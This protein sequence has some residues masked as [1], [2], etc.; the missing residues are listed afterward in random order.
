MPMLPAPPPTSQS[1]SPGAGARTARL[2]ARTSRLVSWPSCSYA[3]SSSPGVSPRRLPVPS[4]THSTAS[5]LRS[6]PGGWSHRSAVPATRRSAGAP[7]CSS[8]TSRLGP[9]P[10]A[11][12]ASATTAG[13]VRSAQS[14]SSRRPWWTSSLAEESGRPTTL[15]TGTSS[16]GQPRRAQASDALDGCG[17][18]VT[19]PAPSSSVTARP[20]PK[21]IGSPLASTTRPSPACSSSR[22][23]SAGSS[24]EGHGTRWAPDA[25]SRPSWR[26]APMTTRA[27]P[28]T[29]RA[30]GPRPAQPSAPMPTTLTSV[31]SGAGGRSV[32]TVFLGAGLGSTIP[33]AYAAWPVRPV[34]GRRRSAGRAPGCRGAPP[35]RR[36]A[37]RA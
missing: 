5:T 17:S 25:G 24:G 6:S 33:A 29:A 34:T 1:S 21:N 36:R 32:V 11:V 16:S 30:D 4:A 13:V 2:I 10:H 7:S 22:P 31:A 8:T 35:P 19:L 37:A 9:N 14:T 15:T 3:V 18:T 23:G 27:R 12:S 26:R 28:R 20:I